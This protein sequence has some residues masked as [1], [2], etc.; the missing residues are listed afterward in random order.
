MDSD[1]KNLKKKK[2][3][4]F[5]EFQK[6]QTCT[7]V[8]EWSLHYMRE[9]C[10]CHWIRNWV[11]ESDASSFLFWWKKKVIGKKNHM[12]DPGNTLYTLSKSNTTV[13]GIISHYDKCRAVGIAS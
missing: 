5:K 12:L 3:K 1:L 8:K 10:C 13:K 6:V 9:T 4:G 7:A 2:K 11:I